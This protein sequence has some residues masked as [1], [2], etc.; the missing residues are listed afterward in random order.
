MV[1]IELVR[2]KSTKAPYPLAERVGMR[3]TEEARR[4]GLLLRPLGNVIVLM[5]PLSTTL[6]ELRQMVAIVT[7][8]I[9]RVTAA[10]G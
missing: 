8:A 10:A 6:R 2:D 5:P 1:G 9:D 3:V 7:Q 4:L